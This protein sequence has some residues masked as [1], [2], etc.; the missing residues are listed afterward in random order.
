MAV[1][2]GGSGGSGSSM[3]VNPGR[4]W[5]KGLGDPLAYFVAKKE[6][7]KQN[8][9]HDHDGWQSQSGLGAQ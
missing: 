9:R 7:A 6:D 4:L 5:G 2:C 8:E 1:V 3:G